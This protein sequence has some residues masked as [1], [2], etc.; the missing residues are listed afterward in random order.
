MADG[1]T[2]PLGQQVLA[3]FATWTVEPV[4]LGTGP[5]PPGITVVGDKTA[6]PIQI[7][8]RSFDAAGIPYRLEPG[9]YMG[10]GSLGPAPLTITV[11]RTQ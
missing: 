7:V 2:T 10:P 11:S 5:V 9:S 6:G 8:M 3:L 1:H 4:F